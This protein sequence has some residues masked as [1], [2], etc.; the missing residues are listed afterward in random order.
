M[1]TITP[2]YGSAGNNIETIVWETL[3]SADTATAAQPAGLAPLAGSVQ[4]TGTF[5]G[6]TITM[7]ISNDGTNWATLRDATGANLTFS[8]AGIA[9]FSTAARYVRPSSAG[10]TGDDVDVTMVLRSQ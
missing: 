6:A 5:G 9:D 8:A 1:A 2:T 7:Q 3:T 10:G 4:A